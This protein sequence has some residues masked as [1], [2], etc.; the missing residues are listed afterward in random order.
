MAI[1]ELQQVAQARATM[2]MRG[3]EPLALEIG[4]AFNR[5]LG[6]HVSAEGI[7]L[8]MEVRVRRDMEGFRVVPATPI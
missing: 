4:P 1:D 5:Q 8:D 7:L 3:Y 2:L 6:A